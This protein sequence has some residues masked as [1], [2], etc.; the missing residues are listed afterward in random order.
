VD[1]LRRS[2][3]RR[4][5]PARVEVTAH[6]KLN[7]S[8]AI[9]PRRA[10]GFHDLVTV[11]QSISLADTLLAERTRS[12]FSLGVRFEP[13]GAGRASV[14][15]RGA[16][17]LVVRAARLVHERLRLPG[18]A[19]FQLVKRIPAAAGLGG[20]SADAAAAIAAVLALH[21]RR[22]P[23]NLRLALAAEL[24]SDVPFALLGGTALGLGRGE[25]LRRLRLARP[26]RALLVVPNWRISTSSAFRA[27][28]KAKYGL[29]GW[30]AALRFAASLGQSQVTASRASRL[31]NTFQRVLGY[32][33]RDFDTLSAR[34]CAAGLLEP[35][36]TGSG[37]GVFAILPERTSTPEVRGR[38]DGAGQVFMVRSIRGGLRLRRT[39]P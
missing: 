33:R 9:G 8:L 18:G 37:S 25:R 3:S 26:F 27:I 15:P 35:R 30:E 34:M 5:P 31:G 20:G 13:A 21:G 6:A 12:G 4:R 10:D 11:L 1:S 2:L 17:N 29:T 22:L 38:F 19:R 23:L 28:D 36:L 24:G 39:Q 32:R 14:V 7:L 16:D